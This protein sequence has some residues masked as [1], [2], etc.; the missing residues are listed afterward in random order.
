[1]LYEQ[2]TRLL[3]AKWNKLVEVWE[4]ALF[5]CF[6]LISQGNRKQGHQLRVMMGE[7][8]VLGVRVERTRNETVAQERGRLNGLGNCRLTARLYNGP[9]LGE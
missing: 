3:E 9:T 5:E 4:L 8:P 2:F 1:M 6:S 7:E